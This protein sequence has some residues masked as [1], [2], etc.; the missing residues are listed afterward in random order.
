MLA[1]PSQLRSGQGDPLIWCVAITLGFLALVWHRLGI[2]SQIYFDE[3]HYVP[4]ARKLLAME[5]V[6]SEH[7]MVGK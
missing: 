4:A 6:N 3:V 7:P 5:S 2:P 1:A